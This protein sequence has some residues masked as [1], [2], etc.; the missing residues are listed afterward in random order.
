[1]ILRVE[2][3]TTTRRLSGPFDYRGTGAVGD[4]VKIPFGRQKLDGVVKLPSG[5]FKPYSGVSTAILLFTN[6]M[7]SPAT[8]SDAQR[9]CA[10]R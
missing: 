9:S 5:V 8:S 6:G 4:V 7:C 3:L 10:K 2:P 1:M